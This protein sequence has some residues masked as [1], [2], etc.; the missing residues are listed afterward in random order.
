MVV[1]GDYGVHQI[2]RQE[3]VFSVRVFEEGFAFVGL[4]GGVGHEPDS[5]LS[6]LCSGFQKAQVAWV[7]KVGAHRD[8]DFHGFF[9]RC[10]VI[11]TMFCDL[12]WISRHG[13][14]RESTFVPSSEG[15]RRLPH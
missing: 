9:R 15:S 12:A 2:Q 7:Q 5:D 10:F 1:N 14:C 3:D 6:M 11:Y 4:H 13:I 8:C